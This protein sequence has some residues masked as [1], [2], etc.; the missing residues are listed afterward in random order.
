MIQDIPAYNG[1]GV[2]ALVDD[3]GKMYIGSSKQVHRRI[4]QH[5]EAIRAGRAAKQIRDAIAAGRS[6]RCVLLEELAY[7]VSTYDLREREFFFIEKH[8]TI[9]HGY[10]TNTRPVGKEKAEEKYQEYRRLF[11]ATADSICSSHLRL[12]APIL[13]P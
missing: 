2:Y 9:A 11:P 1:I 13:P 5:E 10:N 12:A 7:G 3:T 4:K 6:F 8:G